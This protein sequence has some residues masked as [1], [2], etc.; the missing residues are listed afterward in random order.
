VCSAFGG[1]VI[2]RTDVYLAGVYDGAT[3]CE[4]VPF[5]ASIAEATGQSLY[6]CPG[7]RTIMRWME[8]SDGR[9][10]SHD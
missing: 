2:Y 7:M 8:P 5:H 10:D 3:D 4:H 6:L 1:F 9:H